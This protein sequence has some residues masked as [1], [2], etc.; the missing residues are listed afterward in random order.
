M[1]LI[2]RA[3]LFARKH[4][5][6]VKDERSRFPLWKLSCNVLTYAAT[7]IFYV[8]WCIELLS[9]TDHCYFLTHLTLKLRILGIVR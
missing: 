7:T 2:K 6:L 3:E 5:N 9:Q 1:I 8:A 4:S